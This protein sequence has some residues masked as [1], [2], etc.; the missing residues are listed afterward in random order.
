MARSRRARSRACA[1]TR[2]S[3]IPTAAPTKVT[4]TVPESTKAAYLTNLLEEVES[5][6]P[7]EN[8]TVTFT[9]KPYEIVTILLK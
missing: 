7:V 9:I 4:V 5:E 6:L 1:S 8:G 3:S 2:T